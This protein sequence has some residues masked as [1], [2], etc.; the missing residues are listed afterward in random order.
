MINLLEWMVLHTKL[1]L[2]MAFHCQREIWKKGNFAM[3]KFWV[4]K[5]S[6]IF[7]TS[8]LCDIEKRSPLTPN[9]VSL[10]KDYGPFK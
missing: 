3:S 10:E 7:S 2:E 6:A 5:K 8:G 1:Q 4:P 9:C